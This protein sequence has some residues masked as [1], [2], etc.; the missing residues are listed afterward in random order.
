MRDEFFIAKFSLWCLCSYSIFTS[1]SVSSFWTDMRRC[2]DGI[3]NFDCDIITWSASSTESFRCWCEYWWWW[4]DIDD[5]R[6][7]KCWWRLLCEQRKYFKKLFTFCC[8]RF[9]ILRE[10]E[11]KLSIYILTLM[12]KNTGN[13]FLNKISNLSYYSRRFNCASM[14]CVVG[15]NKIK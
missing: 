1:K 15:I 10:A 13:V 14:H 4:S 2:L 9:Y 5:F 3:S 7:L 8:K 11:K 12:E 6:R